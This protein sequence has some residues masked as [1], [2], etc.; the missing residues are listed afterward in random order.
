MSSE[1][2]TRNPKPETMKIIGLTGGIGSGKTTVGRMF[3][4]L[5]VPVYDSDKEAK[6]LMQNSQEIRDG[7]VALF[8]NNAIVGD[9]VNREF[10]SNR[11][12]TDKDLLQQLNGLVHPAIRSHFLSWQRKQTFPYVI[13]EAAV[14]FENSSYPNYDKIILV[15]AP[16]EVRLKRVQARDGSTRK[17]VLDRMKNQWPDSQKRKLSNF[18]IHNTNLEKTRIKVGQIHRTILKD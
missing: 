18:I 12:F 9:Q 10:I 11:V 14:I 17:K 2:K 15:T 8:G 7:L 5:G 1:F 13:Q 16:K 4:E 3:Q 6:L